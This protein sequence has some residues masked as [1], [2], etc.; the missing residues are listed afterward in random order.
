MNPRTVEA[1]RKRAE[2]ALTPGFA[3]RPRHSVEGRARTLAE[4]VRRL[5]DEVERQQAQ[6]EWL[7]RQ[8]TKH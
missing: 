8:V 6:I 4:D 1:M 2:D 3:F 5:A 7:A